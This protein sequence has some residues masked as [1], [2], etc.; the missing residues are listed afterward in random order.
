VIK[1]CL[2]NKLANP[3]DIMRKSIDLTKKHKSI[4]HI[5]FIC[6]KNEAKNRHNIQRQVKKPSK[7]D[8]KMEEKKKES[9]VLI[10]TGTQ[11]E[12]TDFKKALMK[13]KIFPK[14][15]IKKLGAQSV[16]EK[17]ATS[18]STRSESESRASMQGR[19]YRAILRY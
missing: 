19:V 7:P 6:I 3:N 5:P 16:Q 2:A 4:D 1:E 9:V 17:Y 12:A 11:T 8:E 13:A 10:S 15:D 18:A 14:A